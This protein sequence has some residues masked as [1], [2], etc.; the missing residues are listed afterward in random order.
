MDRYDYKENEMHVES[1]FE[2]VDVV[3]KFVLLA[4][5]SFRDTDQWFAII[6]TKRD[7]ILIKDI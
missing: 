4:S 3:V 1:G 2:V 6:Q 7:F 5:C